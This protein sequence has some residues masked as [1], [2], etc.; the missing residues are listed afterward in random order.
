MIDSIVRSA[1][2]VI[3]RTFRPDCCLN[4]TRVM[5]EVFR[6]FAIPARAVVVSVL[7]VNA[8]WVE[9]ALALGRVPDVRELAPAAWALGIDRP[10]PPEGSGWPGHVV[11]FARGRLIDMA[12]G[13]IARPARRIYAPAYVCWLL[14]HLLLQFFRIRRAGKDREWRFR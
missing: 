5:I 6:D 13:N 8:A 4:A 7:A 1:A 9:Q 12:A 2:P 11:V 3:A 14:P 10:G